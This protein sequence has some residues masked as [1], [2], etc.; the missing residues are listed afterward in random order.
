MS[1]SAQQKVLLGQAHAAH[2]LRKSLI[3]AQC[4]WDSYPESLGGG[5]A[6]WLDSLMRAP[7]A[8][9]AARKKA[10]Y[11]ADG[12]CCWKTSPEEAPGVRLLLSVVGAGYADGMAAEPAARSL[13]GSVCMP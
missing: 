3:G 10:L 2:Q 8:G 13:S 1:G 11:R 6:K 4:G 12:E 5:A 7:G 9:N